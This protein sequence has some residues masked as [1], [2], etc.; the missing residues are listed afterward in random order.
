MLTN[1]SACDQTNLGSQACPDALKSRLT[2]K[3]TWF[4]GSHYKLFSAELVESR[5]SKLRNI[6]EYQ[7]DRPLLASSNGVSRHRSG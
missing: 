6:N 2:F 5:I 3:T 1:Q 4:N 7:P